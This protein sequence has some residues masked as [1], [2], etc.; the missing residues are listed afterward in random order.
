MQM[1]LASELFR[2]EGSSVMASWYSSSDSDDTYTSHESRAKVDLA[3]RNLDVA[4]VSTC[5]ED[6][7]SI[8]SLNLAGNSLDSIPPEVGR[9]DALRSLDLSNNRVSL[10]NEKVLRLVI[11]YLGGNELK[12]VPNEIGELEQLETLGL[13]DNSITSIPWTV[14]KLKSLCSLLLHNNQLQTLPREILTLRMLSEL[15]LRG[16]PLVLRF[17]RDMIYDPP[18]LLE[19]ASRVVKVHRVP[20]E[21]QDLP[22]TI[23]EYLS[24]AR[25]CVN[26][27]CAGVYFDTRVGNIKFVDFC[28]KYRIPLLEFLC[29]TYCTRTPYRPIRMHK[30]E[31]SDEAPVPEDRIKKVLLG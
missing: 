19:L 24:T 15:S 8:I 20:F 16:N 30:E 27:K 7:A 18:S 14:C 10:L 23:L 6:D 17:V 13:C 1:C 11:L 3:Y 5:L 26:P 21:E 9:F 2:I 25:Q 12:A 4:A 22:R 28:G 31:P 29:S